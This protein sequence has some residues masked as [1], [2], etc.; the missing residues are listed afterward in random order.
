MC[1]CMANM[2]ARL[3]NSLSRSASGAYALQNPS[4][5]LTHRPYQDDDGNWCCPRCG[6]ARFTSNMAVMGHFRSCKP[7]R[8][9]LGASPDL[10]T[11]PGNGVGG[12]QPLVGDQ[13]VISA[14]ELAAL[15]AEMEELKRHQYNHIQHLS[16]QNAA[17]DG[18]GAPLPVLSRMSASAWA[19][20]G[21]AFAG[22]AAYAW[23]KQS[24]HRTYRLKDAQLSREYEECGRLPTT[25]EQMACR[26]DNRKRRAAF[27]ASEVEG[28]LAGHQQGSTLTTHVGKTV[29]GT[30]IRKVFK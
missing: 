9:A 17:A 5:K 25:D 22:V 4:S 19:A 14:H 30:V 24:A 12:Q 10:V 15:R 2:R 3:R 13:V 1:M 26:A 27:E 18:I 28:I 23:H 29:A 6:S 8:P 20:V 7:G 21:T 11:T 16:V